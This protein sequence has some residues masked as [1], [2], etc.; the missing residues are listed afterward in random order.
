M[1][2]IENW[3]HSRRVGRR[4][5]RSGRRWIGRILNE[6]FAVPP[7]VVFATARVSRLL[8]IDFLPAVL[9]NIANQH[10]AGRAI[11]TVPEG[12]AQA[13]QPNFSSWLR[14]RRRIR[15]WIRIVRRNRV[16]PG[17]R[18]HMNSKH[19]PEECGVVLGVATGL[20]VAGPEI[21]SITAITRSDVKIVIVI[22]T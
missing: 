22:R 13:E 14:G 5:R 1:W 21:V 16:S 11:E 15:R 6:T 3:I 2:I 4:S 7:S 18:I 9:A 19:F 8:N 10:A 12:I 20:D 17:R